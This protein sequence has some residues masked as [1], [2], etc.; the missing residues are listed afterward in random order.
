MAAVAALVGLLGPALSTAAPPTQR[1]AFAPGRI[2][3]EAKAGATDGQFKAAIAAHGGRSLGKLLGLKVHMVAL[4][5]GQSEEAI[6]ARLARHPHVKFAE[7]DKLVTPSA[8]TNDPL[9]GSQWH[10]P[11]IDAP[12]AWDSSNGTGTIIAIL[13]TGVDSTHP[14]L[15]VQ[16]VSGWN[17]YDNNSDTSDVHGHGTAVAGAAAAAANNGTGVG[18]VAWGARLMPIRVSDPNGYAYGSTIAQALTWA[19]DNNARVANISFDGV[20]E[21]YDD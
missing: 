4:P 17:F 11:K 15:A 13:D 19:A 9:L 12:T 8:M 6:A 21:S 7:L 16:M 20:A 3:V 2:L 5:P 10:L 18:S 14:D 1:P